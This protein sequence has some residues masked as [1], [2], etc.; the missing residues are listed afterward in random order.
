MWELG[1]E[2]Y[3]KTIILAT[4]VSEKHKTAPLLLHTSPHPKH[5]L[6]N[7]EKTMEVRIQKPN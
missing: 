1:S 5:Q 4:I 3:L 2:V 6:Y 7:A